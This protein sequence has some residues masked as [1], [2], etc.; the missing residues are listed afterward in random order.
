MLEPKVMVVT[1]TSHGQDRTEDGR[2]HR[3]GVPAHP[4]LEREADPRDGGRRQACCR[5]RPGDARATLSL[6]SGRHAVGCGPVGHDHRQRAQAD[7]QQGDPE[8]DHRPVDAQRRRGATAES[9]PRGAKGERPTATKPA[10]SEPT[11][12]TPNVP[13]SPSLDGHRRIGAESAQDVEVV[14]AEPD[15]PP[16]HLAGDEERGQAGDPA[17]DAQ[18][19]RLRPESALGPRHDIG[20]L[21][22]GERQTLGQHAA[23]ISDSTWREVAARTRR[24]G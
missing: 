6:Q 21:D 24:R 20:R 14:R 13:M 2:A 9:G 1:T 16:D 22:V 17:E 18:G 7:Q 3:D 19:D 10:S 8:A 4:R 12:T 11:S 15:P 5:G 23:R